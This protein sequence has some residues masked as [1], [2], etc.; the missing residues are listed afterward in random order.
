MTKARLD[1]PT[2]VRA[3]DRVNGI[4][5]HFSREIRRC[6]SNLATTLVPAA[7]AVRVGQFGQ[8]TGAA[9]FA[10]GFFVILALT[11][12]IDLAMME[13]HLRIAKSLQERLY[14]VPKEQDR[15]LIS[16]TIPDQMK[17]YETVMELTGQRYVGIMP[18]GKI[19]LGV[20]GGAVAVPVLAG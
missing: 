12:L 1:F 2:N 6:E 7:V 13:R 19:L 18:T 5:D 14:A 20:V 11:F 10:M 9:A 8:T 16:A 4:V 3:I 17:S 15:E